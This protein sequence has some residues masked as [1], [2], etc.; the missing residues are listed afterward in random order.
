VTDQS[1]NLSAAL[2]RGGARFNDNR[3][4]SVCRRHRL[5]AFG[6][7]TPPPKPFGGP[8]TAMFDNSGYNVIALPVCEGSR[9]AAA[10]FGLQSGV[11]PCLPAALSR[12]AHGCGERCPQSAVLP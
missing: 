3:L 12:L 7:Q 6:E 9:Y 4:S 10:H 2:K 5:I 1:F 11:S 8:P